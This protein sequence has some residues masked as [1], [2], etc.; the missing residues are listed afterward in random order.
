VDV[1]YEFNINYSQEYQKVL[2]GE[3]ASQGGLVSMELIVTV[4]VM[5][6]SCPLPQ[7]K[8]WNCT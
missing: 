6:I 7:A 5:I 8:Y 2:L 1:S 4:A 3:L